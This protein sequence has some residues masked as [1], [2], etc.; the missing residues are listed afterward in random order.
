[1]WLEAGLERVKTPKDEGYLKTILPE[2]EGL[3]LR[4]DKI[5]NSYLESILDSKTRT[6]IEHQLWMEILK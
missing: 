6:K 5:V 2:L 4:I 3:K 1:M